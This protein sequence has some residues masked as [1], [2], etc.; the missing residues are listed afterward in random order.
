MHAGNLK[1]TRSIDKS[2]V[3][4]DTLKNKF[5]RAVDGPKRLSLQKAS[6]PPML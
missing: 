2:T 6:E 5:V 1:L 4:L 3:D